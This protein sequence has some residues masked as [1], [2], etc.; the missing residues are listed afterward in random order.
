M[1]LFETR[2]ANHDQHL[3]SIV[4]QGPPIDTYRALVKSGRYVCRQ[5]GRVAANAENLCDPLDL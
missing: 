3:C 2:H 1:P 4:A 5:C